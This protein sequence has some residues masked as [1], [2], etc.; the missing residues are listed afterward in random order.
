MMTVAFYCVVSASLLLGTMVWGHAI[1]MYNSEACKTKFA[2]GVVIMEQKVIPDTFRNVVVYRNGQILS[3]GS[4]YIS[5]ETLYVTIAPF[6]LEVFIEAK[7][8]IIDNSIHD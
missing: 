5:G 8:F 7:G 3:N 4:P 2:L 6:S 1:Y